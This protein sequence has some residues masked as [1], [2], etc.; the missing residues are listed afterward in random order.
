MLVLKHPLCSNVNRP[1]F[2][3]FAPTS[4]EQVGVSTQE[5]AAPRE[6]NPCLEGAKSSSPEQFTL[7]CVLWEAGRAI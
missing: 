7:S 5:P 3:F 2:V 4:L 6:D 1:A